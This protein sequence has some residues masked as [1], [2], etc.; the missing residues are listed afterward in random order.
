MQDS[1]VD[2]STLDEVCKRMGYE[3]RTSARGLV[4]Y[5]DPRTPGAFPLVFDF[6][7][8]PLPLKDVVRNFDEN[9]V[10]LEVFNA[11]LEEVTF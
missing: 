5:R 3:R 8:G 4:L 9:G 6:R 10:N 11:M 1:F 7:Q 2:E